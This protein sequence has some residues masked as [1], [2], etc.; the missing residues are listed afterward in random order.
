MARVDHLDGSH[1]SA[2]Y[3]V[4]YGYP[5]ERASILEEA[6]QG[7][8]DMRKGFGTQH[9]LVVT[10]QNIYDRLVTS[11]ITRQARQWRPR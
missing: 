1:Q 10:M 4:R 7:L 5:H 3:F 9:L 11:D 2:G 6:A 8:A